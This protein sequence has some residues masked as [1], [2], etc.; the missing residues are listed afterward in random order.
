MSI[1]AMNMVFETEGLDHR[2]KLVMLIL[3]DYSDAEGWS[4]PGRQKLVKRSGMSD[5][6]VYRI[7][8]RLEEKG[9]L[10]QVRRYTEDG[11]RTSN[12]YQL[13][14]ERLAVNLTGDVTRQNEGGYPSTVTAYEPSE[15]PPEERKKRAKET[16]RELPLPS[17][18]E[19][20]EEHRKK[21]LAS[22]LDLDHE[23]EL[24]R[25]HAETHGRTA[26]R[27][28]S[29][30]SMWLVKA[31][32]KMSNVTPIR[33]GIVPAIP[34]ERPTKGMTAAERQAHY[35]AEAEAERIRLEEMSRNASPTWNRGDV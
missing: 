10:T 17:D 23:V 18:W 33:P 2:E 19:P 29:A 25:L 22:G 12:G 5:S 7:I 1:K 6:T 15:E 30:F 31:A 35:A 28:N 20:T 34:V 26:K 8:N 9:F 3:A 32:S 4:Y 11:V 21:A 16:L 24:F 27:W 13:L 14:P